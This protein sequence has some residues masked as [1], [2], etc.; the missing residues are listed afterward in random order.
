MF[1]LKTVLMLLGVALGILGGT[2]GITFWYADGL[3]Y[4]SKAPQACVNCHIMQNQYDSW[5]KASHHTAAACVDC[6]LPRDF[7]GK[8]LAKARNGYLH[9]KGFTLGNFH[10]PIRITPSNLQILQ[11]NHLQ[12]TKCRSG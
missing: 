5:Q 2:G 10:E 11:E 3:S 12:C 4:L 7:R 6:H 9:S 8:Y 1:K